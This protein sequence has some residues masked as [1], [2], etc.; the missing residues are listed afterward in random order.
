[1]TALR[2]LQRA[3]S[4]EGQVSPSTIDVVHSSQNVVEYRFS[5]LE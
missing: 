4:G 5:E 1:L 2:S 3:R